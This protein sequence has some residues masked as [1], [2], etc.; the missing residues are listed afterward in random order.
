[1]TLSLSF[2]PPPGYISAVS[3]VESGPAVIPGVRLTDRIGVG[4]LT[5]LI[6]RDLVDEVLAETGRAEQRS[7]LLPARVVVYYVLGLCLFF[8]EGY[9]EVMRLLV[10]GLRFLGSWRKDWQIPT[11][12]AIAQARARLGAEPLRMLFERV[13]A[14]CAQLGTQ[15]AWLGTR[16]LMAIDGFVLDVPDTA[17]NDAAFGRS[18]GEKNPAPFPQVRVVGLGECGTHAIV[19]ARMAAWRVNERI[20]AEELTADFQP[21]MLV[22]A[23]RGFYGYLLWQA[24]A[25]SGADLLWRMPAGPNLPVVRTF[26]DGSYESFLLDPK[27]RGRRA[28]QR[29]RGSAKIEE[30]AGIPVRVIEYEVTNREGKDE[31]FCLITTIMDPQDASSAELAAAYE[32]R[33]EFESSLDEIKTHQRGRGGVL[34]SKS[35]EMIRQEI[36]AFLLTHYAI[37]HLMCEAADQADVDPDRLSFMRTL[38]LIRRQVTDQ[39]AFSPRQAQERAGRGTRGNS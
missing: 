30:P 4:I 35:P 13:A 19:S 33:W 38:R 10:S 36:W 21:G 15:G 3:D 5:R 27:V 37:R 18:G 23:D 32:E 28:T 29:H 8:G 9:E 16:R 12:G 17:E 2:W 7:R 25:A 20:L 14:P 39:A 6:D 11:T 1:L 34:R 24:A 31:I 26:P 22:I